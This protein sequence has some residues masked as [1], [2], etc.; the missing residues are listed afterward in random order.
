MS[1]SICNRESMV[2]ILVIYHCYCNETLDKNTPG[3]KVYF[4]S[5]LR[6]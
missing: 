3:R 5:A 1:G 2:S 6:T 4:D